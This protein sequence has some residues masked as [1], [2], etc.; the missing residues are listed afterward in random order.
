[1]KGITKEQQQ[2]QVANMHVCMYANHVGG[3]EVVDA[4]TL[5]AHTCM[6]GGI[7]KEATISHLSSHTHA[8]YAGNNGKDR[9]TLCMQNPS[10]EG[11]HYHHPGFHTKSL[12]I[13]V[14]I[15]IKCSPITT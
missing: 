7:F 14:K 9:H 8:W 13:S 3:E 5:H 10:D 4:V 2:Q 12:V 11:M 15:I 6:R 1:M